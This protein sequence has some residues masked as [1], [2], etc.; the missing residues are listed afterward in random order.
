MNSNAQQ[1]R[2]L[3]DG[4]KI[5]VAPGAYDGLTAR[6]IQDRGFPAA[7]LGGFTSSVRRGIVDALDTFDGRLASAR[8]IVEMV[9][10]PLIV[11]VENG[12]GGIINL[13][14][15]IRSF[16]RVGIAGVQL[17]DEPF[18][19][20]LYHASEGLE[21]Y[22]EGMALD[23]IKRALD[24]RLSSDFVIVARTD[25]LRVTGNVEATVDRAAK[26][27][28]VGADVIQIVGVKNIHEAAT[29]VNALPGVPLMYVGGLESNPEPSIAELDSLGYRIAIYTYICLWA[30]ISGVDEVLGNLK[31]EGLTGVPE[32]DKPHLRGRVHDLIRT[33]EQQ[34]VEREALQ[35]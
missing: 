1:L 17:D 26:M 24:A 23:R 14:H 25:L 19:T 32:K 34:A 31:G 4:G 15:T 29:I 30:M 8:D 7:Y 35:H 9:D 20:A 22:E 10:I 5:I 3:L 12:F 6:M 28:A 21:V 11:D 18:K 2:A 16:D 27:H 13:T 33:A